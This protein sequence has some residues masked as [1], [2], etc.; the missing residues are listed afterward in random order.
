MKLF[1][2]F[3][4][5]IISSITV[6]AQVQWVNADSAYTPLP[7][8]FHVYYNADSLD[9]KA[10]RAFYAEAD[11]SDK[12][13]LFETDTTFKRRLTPAAYYEKNEG[14]LLVVNSTFFSFASNQNLNLV[15]KN[16]RMVGFNI[17][18]LDGKGKDTLTYRHAFNGAFGISKK[19]KAD[20]AWVYSDSSGK[21]PLASQTVIPFFKDSSKAV[22]RPAA[23]H[24]K[25]KMQSAV[26]GG[27]VLLQHGE[28]VI[29]NNEEQKF[30]GKAI[31]DKHPRTLIGY[32][33]AGKII[34]MVVEGRNP[35]IASGVTLVQ[36]AGLMKELDCM[37]ALNLDGG[38]SSCMLING[39]QTIWP[40]DKGIQRPVP[41]VFMIK[42]KGAQ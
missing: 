40:S 7:V 41:A 9:G 27:P 6:T 31:D 39:K 11:L 37:E 25:W 4:V 20:I 23:A 2:P 24:R 5:A 16:G 1:F 35:G 15:I 33:A 29:S 18:T 30:Q 22:K 12:N 28:V 42:T 32:T 19:R 36:A 21:Y 17:H 26:A 38:G 34:I 13:L 3:A 14:P 10:F 8:G